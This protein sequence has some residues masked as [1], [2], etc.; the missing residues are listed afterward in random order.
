MVCSLGLKQGQVLPRR[1]APLGASATCVQQKDGR[2][3]TVKGGRL[4]GWVRRGARACKSAARRCESCRMKA[5]ARRAA[6]LPGRPPAPERAR[7]QGWCTRS[8][9]VGRC[10][11]SLLSSPSSTERRSSLRGVG[12]GGAWTRGGGRSG[13][14]AAAVSAGRRCEGRRRVARRAGRRRFPG[15]GAGGRAGER[16]R[17]LEREHLSF[18]SLTTWRRR[19]RLPGSAPAAGGLTLPGPRHPP[20]RQALAR[21]AEPGHLM[22]GSAG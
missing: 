10:A 12:W 22:G 4:G 16:G 7:T 18:T 13:R 21:H 2:G 1:S 3:N 14:G 8:A 5:P 9:A 20:R 19:E 6:R 11:G 17:G 15:R